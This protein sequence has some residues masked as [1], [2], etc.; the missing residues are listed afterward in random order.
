MGQRLALTRAA[1]GPAWV[2]L[3][4]RFCHRDGSSMLARGLGVSGLIISTRQIRLH[5]L[6]GNPGHG[7]L[8]LGL[9][10]YIWVAVAC[11]VVLTIAAVTCVL[12]AMLENQPM[13]RLKWFSTATLGALALTIVVNAIAEF[14][15][16]GFNAFLPD[17][18]TGY[19]LFGG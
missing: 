3:Q 5:I 9:G 13:Q 12:H 10:L 2:I 7:E 6:P 16:A 11:L 15:L 17:N 4:C 8:V 18:P 1:I 14:T 19:Q